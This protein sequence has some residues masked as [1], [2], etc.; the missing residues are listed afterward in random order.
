MLFDGWSYFAWSAGYDTWSR[1]E[2]VAAMYSAASSEEL[3]GLV[4]EN[5]IRF[6]V[7]DAECRN[8]E[9][10]TVRED[11]ISATFGVGYTEGD[12]GNKLTIYDTE[13]ILN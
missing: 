9:S 4:E 10:Y 13:D 8:S 2:Q 12:G 11:V 7:V 1:D 6:I 3:I 5:Q